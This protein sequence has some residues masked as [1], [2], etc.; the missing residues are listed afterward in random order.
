MSRNPN[1]TPRVCAAAFLR[2]PFRP[3]RA[4]GSSLAGAT[5]AASAMAGVLPVGVRDSAIAAAP[6][7][8]WPSVEV[9]GMDEFPVEYRLASLGGL[10]GS[11]WHFD[12]SLDVVR[13]AVLV[14]LRMSATVWR[15]R[16]VLPLT[17][18]GLGAPMLGLGD[19]VEVVFAR[20]RTPSLRRLVERGRRWEYRLGDLPED[21]LLRPGVTR[22]LHEL[23]ESGG[24]WAL[25]GDSLV[26]HVPRLPQETMPSPAASQRIPALRRAFAS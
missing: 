20:P 23:H 4:R 22:I 2:E 14:G 21:A 1:P 12:E 26:V 25:V 10:L 19:V 9:G 15:L 6:A 17:P 5:A 24:A 13:T 16:E 11:D 7:S 18:F 8:S 3:A